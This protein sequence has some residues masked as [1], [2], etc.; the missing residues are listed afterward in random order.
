MASGEGLDAHATAQVNNAVG[1]A[2]AYDVPLDD[3][4]L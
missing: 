4:R 2:F 3:A 1:V